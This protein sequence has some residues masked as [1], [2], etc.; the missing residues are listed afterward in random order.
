MDH[1]EAADTE[2]RTRAA[3]EKLYQSYFAGDGDGMVDTMSEDVWV[4]FLGQVDFRGKQRARQFFGQNTPLLVNLD[5]R[6]RKLIVDGEY[7][8][9][10]WE[11]SAQTIHGGQ[12]E[13]HGVDVFHVRDDEITMVHENNDIRIHRQ[14]FETEDA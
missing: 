14:H 4:R 1:A 5:F 2:Q 7:A 8:A 6:I 10:L 13:N 9:A 12:Y 11:E 3:V